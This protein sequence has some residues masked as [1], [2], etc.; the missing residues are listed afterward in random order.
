MSEMIMVTDA[1]WLNNSFG[2]NSFNIIRVKENDF[3]NSIECNH[4][5]IERG[6]AETDCNYK[7]IVSYCLISSGDDLFITQRT[8]KQTEKRLHNRY[9]FGV[10]GHINFTDTKNSN[11]VVTGML[12]ELFEEVDIQCAYIYDFL[13]IINDNSSEVNSVHTGVCFL[14]KLDN[15]MCSVKETEKMRGFWINKSE[16][17]QYM[18]ELEGWSKI[19][20]NSFCGRSNMDFV[21][22]LNDKKYKNIIAENYL[23]VPAVLETIL[24]SDNVLE[25]DKYMIA[26]Y[27]GVI[28]PSDV[29]YPQVKNYSHS[30]N[31]KQQGI[32]LKY[33]SINDFFRDNKI[34]LHEQYT[35]INLID[36]DFFSDYIFDVLTSRKHIIC[37][38]EY[39][40]L[41]GSTGDYAGHVSIIVNV[42]VNKDVVYL[43]DP[44]PRTPG[45]KMISAYNLYHA[46][47]EAKDGLW[48][49][50]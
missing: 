15:K 33:D 2:E 43:L 4:E 20:I 7:Q 3:I 50:S 21:T 28:L 30:D 12:R 9:S 31:P 37:G 44:G 47:L 35:K 22:G 38:Y 32:I 11:V 27:F 25:I 39:H 49:I 45:L 5:F 29:V 40:S 10:G 23:C 34:P 36:R 14:V 13:G 1:K 18:D 17:S 16:I 41:Y 8:I 48:V 26:N 19:L 46:I 24:K 6:I 42:D